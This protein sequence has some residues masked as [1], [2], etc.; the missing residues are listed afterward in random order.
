MT[1]NKFLQIRILIAITTFV[2][3]S[4][5]LISF[6]KKWSP[7]PIYTLLLLLSFATLANGVSYLSNLIKL[8]INHLKIITGI[9]SFIVFL[10]CLFPINKEASLIIQWIVLIGVSLSSILISVFSLFEFTH[11]FAIMRVYSFVFA[12][13]S[14]IFTFFIASMILRNSSAS[15]FGIAVIS[16]SSVLF[17]ICIIVNLFA[18]SSLK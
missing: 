12:L 11:E 7:G 9:F 8:N 17:L 5:T 18:I 3:L 6:F 16:Y 2:V 14:G 10:F 4:G 15:E 1:N 13:N